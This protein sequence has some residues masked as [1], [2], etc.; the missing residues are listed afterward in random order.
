MTDAGLTETELTEGMLAPGAGESSELA[1]LVDDVAILSTEQQEHVAALHGEDSWGVDAAA[2]SF[3]FTA[4]DGTALVCRAHLLG[5]AAPGPGSWLWGW[6]NANGFPDAFFERSEAVRAATEAPELIEPEVPLAAGL[7]LRL[8]LAAKSVTGIRAHYSAP[9]GNGT[10]VW[11][12][13]EHPSLE[14][15][16]PTVVRTLEALRLTL[17][18]VQLTDHRAAVRSWARHREVAVSAVTPAEDL[19]PAAEAVRLEVR[20]GEVVVGFD[21]AG[22]IVN[23]R[24]T[25]SAA[26]DGSGEPDPSPAAERPRGFLSRLLGRD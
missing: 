25:A 11:L 17:E 26:G 15:P 23:L 22:R 9:V 3:T 24:A 2:Q 13:I 20:D 7:P 5:T 19:A 14:L 8:T 12:L 1:A 6:V 4:A 21:Q 18:G 10:R 16:A